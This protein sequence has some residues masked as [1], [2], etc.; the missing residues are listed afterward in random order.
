[1]AVLQIGRDAC[2]PLIWLGEADPCETVAKVRE[3]DPP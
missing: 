2:E 1:M 3:N